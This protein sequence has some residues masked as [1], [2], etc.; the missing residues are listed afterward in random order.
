[1]RATTARCAGSAPSG[2]EARTASPREVVPIAPAG[3]RWPLRGAAALPAEHPQRRTSV[4]PPVEGGRPTFGRSSLGYVRI[5]RQARP[6][7]GVDAHVVLEVRRAHD[8]LRARSRSARRR[9]TDARFSTSMISVMRNA[10]SSA[11][12]QRVSS[13]RGWR[14][15]RRVPAPP[16][17]RCS[18][19]RPRAPR[20][21]CPPPGR[22]RGSGR[23]R[24]RRRTPRACRRRGR[25]RSGRATRARTRAAAG[26]AGA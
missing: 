11:K 23:R 10:P 6:Q 3:L 24:R 4:L 22:G 14:P 8:A 12:A 20:G 9:A 26:R 21:R 25:P 13:R 15:R 16:A 5:G 17:R 1:M 7:P 2:P 19:A 18:R